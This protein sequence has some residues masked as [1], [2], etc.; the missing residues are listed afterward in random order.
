[1]NQIIIKIVKML[2]NDDP[3]LVIRTQ[4]YILLKTQTF[5]ESLLYNIHIFCDL[6]QCEDICIDLLLRYL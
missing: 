3:Q 1:M 5:F 2:K 4:S 6:N